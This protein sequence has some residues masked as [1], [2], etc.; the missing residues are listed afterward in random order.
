MHYFFLVFGVIT[1]SIFVFLRKPKVTLNM[2]IV[3]GIASLGFI[4]TGLFSF[5][6]NPD[7]PQ[8]L[9]ALVVA[10]ACFGLIGDIVLDLKYL[11]KADADKYLNTGFISFLIG[12]L[13]YA[14]GMIYTYGYNL[15][16]FG[17]TALCVVC[18]VAF[19]FIAE[20]VAKLNYGKFKAVT[21]IYTAILNST[22]GMS[23]AYA[24]VKPCAHSIVMAVGLFFFLLSDI[25]LSR[26]YFSRKEKDHSDRVAVV[27]NHATYYV[28]QFLIAVSLILI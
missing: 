20:K 17:F 8:Y 11:Y 6:G 23:V 21:T 3:K 14:A 15:Y 9:G 1:A 16:V 26:T 7:C 28:A 12:H 19:A 27:I 25:I 22:F 4:F 13:F 5:I 18:G 10:G 24:V 2:V